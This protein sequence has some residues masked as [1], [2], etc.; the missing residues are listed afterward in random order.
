M[1]FDQPAQTNE[2][3]CMVENQ[4]GRVHQSVSASK[5]VFRLG[6]ILTLK[7]VE[8][9]RGK[10]SRLIALFVSL[11]LHSRCLQAAEQNE[12]PGRQCG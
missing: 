10:G 12:D 8:A 2:R 1:C 11:R 7:G 4:G 3:A 9:L 5:K 6:E